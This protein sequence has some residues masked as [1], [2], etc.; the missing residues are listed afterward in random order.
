MGIKANYA[1]S[2]IKHDQ[3]RTNYEI[4][5][6]AKSIDMTNFLGRLSD[7]GR[8]NDLQLYQ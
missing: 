5:K 6:K 3:L 7:F 1:E 2:L 4:R 8:W